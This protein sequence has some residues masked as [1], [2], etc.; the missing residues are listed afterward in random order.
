MVNEERIAY[1][2][3]QNK[4]KR[5]LAVLVSLVLVVGMLPVSAF[6]LTE[7][8]NLLNHPSL[9]VAENGSFTSTEVPM[10]QGDGKLTSSAGWG[11]IP[12]DNQLNVWI[13]STEMTTDE[14]NDGSVPP[15][16]TDIFGRKWTLEKV[17]LAG[18][19]TPITDSSLS[20]A[21]VILSNSDIQAATSKENYIVDI[22][23]VTVKATEIY[24]S[25]YCYSVLYGWK[26]EDEGGLTDPE[27]Y[28]VTYDF[29]LPDG[30]TDKNVTVY[31]LLEYNGKETLSIGE[32]DGSLSQV[33]TALE[34]LEGKVYS[35]QPY[36]VP[37]VDNQFIGFLVFDRD[38]NSASEAN[39]NYKGFYKFTGW[40]V[41]DG[42]DAEL[43]PIGST[44]DDISDLSTGGNKNK[45][46]KFVPK[47]EEISP[48]DDE[49][50]TAA[51]EQLPL[52]LF[53]R[54]AGVSGLL[55]QWVND[56]KATDEDV[57]L[58]K[59]DILHHVPYL[60]FAL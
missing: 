9:R 5:M 38:R 49:A 30:L 42:P 46:I 36:Q 12:E 20:K 32:T 44:I 33:K 41:D 4:A 11:V 1:E 24:P 31:P 10:L 45:E 8:A 25:Y 39:R 54:N 18:Y 56:G 29:T 57:T 51:A 48:L 6:A 17:A 16:F 34:D 21:E 43:Y 52:D 23:N 26:C 58:G 50:L 55:S 22:S 19:T 47:W 59:D 7:G 15:Y 40:K 53:K 37:Y 14:K 2:T 28:I 35:G 13:E 3:A 27:S 60:F